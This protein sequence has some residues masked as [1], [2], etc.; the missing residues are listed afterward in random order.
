MEQIDLEKLDVAITYMQRIADGKNP[1]NNLPAE[2]DDVLNNPNVI[3][4]MFFVKEILEEVKLNGGCIGKK[5]SR[6]Q[7]EAMKEDFPFEVLNKFEYKEDLSLT[8][9]LQ[10]INEMMDTNLYKKLTYQPFIMWLMNNGYIV[11]AYNKDLGKEI[12]ISSEKG[13]ELGIKSELKTRSTGSR[14][15]LIT[16]NQNAQEFLVKNMEII[17]SIELSEEDS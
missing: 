11:E 3:R 5:V 10:Q 9:F 14:Y 12:K 13:R 1:V 2:D 8:R 16:Y 17:L 6:K 7:R 4:C 15:M